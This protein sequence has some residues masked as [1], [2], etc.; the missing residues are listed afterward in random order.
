[1]FPLSA[2]AYTSI[3]TANS[4]VK[5][6]KTEPKNWRHDQFRLY[7]FKDARKFETISS[8]RWNDEA[9]CII[10]IANEAYG[11]E[12]SS[13]KKV[14]LPKEVR[15][16][17]WNIYQ[18]WA[19]NYFAKVFEDDI[20]IKE[21]SEKTKSVEPEFVSLTEDKIKVEKR[22]SDFFSN[23]PEWGINFAIVFAIIYMLILVY[24][25]LINVF[26]NR[27]IKDES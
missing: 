15:E 12:I 2:N 19:N 25:T 8:A 22:G 7:Y 27:K 18:K 20:K 17:I 16:F 13:P 6:L 23:I 1:M 3:D 26:R 11:V 9:D 10:W 21:T 14:V 24:F 4:I 5:S